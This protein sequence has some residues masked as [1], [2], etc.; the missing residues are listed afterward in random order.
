MSVARICAVSCVELR[1]VVVR[2]TPF[3]RTVAPLTKPEPFTVK[4]NA[5]PPAVALDGPRLLIAELTAKLTAVEVPP[6]GF[7]TVIGNVPIPAISEARIVA[8][9]W[10][11][12][13]KV[14]GR[15]EP[16]K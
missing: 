15:S 2:L 8:F 1:N 9:N 12:L 10:V 13:R 4:V 3:K 16:L 14:V 11:L 6:R 5:G 7:I